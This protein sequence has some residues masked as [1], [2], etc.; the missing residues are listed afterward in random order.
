MEFEPCVLSPLEVAVQVTVV[1]GEDFD[2]VSD[3]ELDCNR[4]I[5]VDVVLGECHVVCLV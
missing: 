1:E 4:H 5:L 3:G 2:V